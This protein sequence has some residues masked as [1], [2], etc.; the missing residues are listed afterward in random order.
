VL[1]AFV[2]RRTIDGVR[3]ILVAIVSLACACGSSQPAPG[4]GAVGHAAPDAGPRV[5]PPLPEGCP[6]AYGEATGAC[7]WEQ[8]RSNCQ[9]PEGQCHCGVP[10]VCGGAEVSPEEVARVPSSWQCSLW[11]PKVRADGCPG[12]IGGTCTEEG[13]ECQYGDC[14]VAT[15]RCEKGQWQQVEAICPP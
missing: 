2:T 15:Y 9:Y 12:E 3:W 8:A 4:G 14:C 13:K 6:A 1:H 11:P 5:I 10:P 7:D